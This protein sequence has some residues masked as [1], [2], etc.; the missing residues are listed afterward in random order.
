MNSN[1]AAIPM[2]TSREFPEWMVTQALAAFLKKD[3]NRAVWLFDLPAETRQQDRKRISEL[4]GFHWQP[5]EADGESESV[6]K[7]QDRG[8]IPEP[9]FKTLYLW[10][11]ADFRYWTKDRK[12]QLIIEAKGTAGAS[13]RDFEQAKRYFE[14]LR[15]F[16]AK[17]AVIYFVPDPTGYDWLGWLDK[18]AKEAGITDEMQVRAGVVNLKTE[19]LPRVASELVRVVGKALVETAELL[20][21]AL[22]FPEG[23]DTSSKSE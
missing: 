11:T 2:S 22:R 23:R 6:L 21:V 5:G 8:E 20:E 1:K 7:A 17:G 3:A 19:V 16:P 13:R 4:C 14:Y 15:A 10:K 18:R 12:K 9:D